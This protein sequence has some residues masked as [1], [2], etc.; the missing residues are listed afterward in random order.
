MSEPGTAQPKLNRAFSHAS[1]TDQHRRRL[2]SLGPD[3]L[4]LL[5]TPAEPQLYAC[6][7]DHFSGI[8]VQPGRDALARFAREILSFLGEDNGV[9]LPP[10]RPACNGSHGGKRIWFLCRFPRGGGG[11]VPVA[12]RYHYDARNKLVRY[13][14]QDA[15]Q[16][17]A[18]KLNAADRTR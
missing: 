2:G 9:T 8:G 1:I 15:A 14:S 5:G 7:P 4:E 13:A 12:D 18:D 11:D 17:A 10:W 16:R 3:R 6:G